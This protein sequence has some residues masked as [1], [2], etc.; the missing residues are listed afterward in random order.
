MKIGAWN[1]RTLMDSGTRPERITAIVGHELARYSIAIAA[2]SET[3]RA[4]TGNLKEV[5]AGYTFYWSGKPEL[6]PRESGVGF[7]IRND[8]ASN[9]TSLPKGL[10]DRL[11]TLRLPLSGN[12]HLTLIS[13]YA[14]T[15]MY[16]DEV[17]EQ[18]YKSLHDAIRTVPAKDKLV[19]LGDFNA[20]VGRNHQAW[21]G[22]LGPHGYG[23]ENSNGLMLLSLCSEESLVITNSIFEH[24]EAHKVTWMHPRSKHWHTIDYIITRRRDISDILDTRALRGADCWTDHILLRCKARFSIHKPQQKK[25][26]C[27]KSK[28]DVSKLKNR[29]VQDEL[30]CQLSEKLANISLENTSCEQAWTSFRDVVF[31]TSEST[32]GFSKRK[33][34]DWFDQSDTEILEQIKQKRAAHAAWLCDKNSSAKYNQFKQ[35]RTQVQAKTRLLKDQWWAAKAVQI[36]GHADKNETKELFAGLKRVFGPSSSTTTPIR[37]QEGRLLT[38]KEDILKQ[39]RLHFSSLLNRTSNVTQDALNTIPQRPPILLLDVPPDEV[40]TTAAIKQLQIGKAAGPDGIPPE[41]FKAGGQRLIHHLTELFQLFWEKGELPQDFR[42]ANI[43]HLYKNKG[44]K[45]QCDNHRGI[46]LLSIAGKIFAR[47][48]LNRISKHLLD[49]VV[50]ESQCGFRKQRGTVDMI[51]AVRQLQ[52]KCIEQHKD[53]HLLFIDLTKAFDTVSRPGLW[54]ILQRLGCPPKFVQMIRAFHDGMFG[55][56]IENGEASDP[57][58]VSNGVKQGCVLAPTLF[59]LLFAQM[60]SAA[61]KESDAGISIHYRTDGSVFNLRRLQSHTKVKKAVVR[62]FLFADDCALACHSE[63]DLQSLADCFATASKAFGLTVSLRKT[64]VLRQLAPDTY[65]PPPNIIME[66]QS[67]KNVDSFR[68]LGSCINS[69]GNLDDEVTFRLSRAAQAFG[70]LQ[71]RVWKEKGIT[72]KT[73]I[74]VYRAV[75]LPSLLYGCETWT[76]Y[77]RHIRKMEQ[78]H[79]RCLRRILRV[80]WEDRIPNQ[81]I[82]RKAGIDGVEV[83]LRKAQLRWSGHVIRMDD[84]R[85]PKQLFFAELAHGKRHQG[86]QRKRY[87][88]CLKVTLKSCNI[89]ISNW[90]QLAQDRNAWRSATR[91]GTEL[92]EKTRLDNLDAKRQD[93]KSRASES[94][95]TIPCPECGRLCASE[96]GLRSHLR[97]HRH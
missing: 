65:R 29:H 58:P 84:W 9:L 23:N 96:F 69:C 67:L 17:K 57:F 48:L 80:S 38:D 19:I 41:V 21:P 25:P 2:L 32:L 91:K 63:E 71:N 8:I 12:T 85:L 46:S 83:L 49:D 35:L 77:R 11:M 52:E 34:Q 28:L 39:W 24:C 72:T 26:S 75:V 92:F 53:L 54:A 33:H 1:V 79:L 42:D 37:N 6:E 94:V 89:P 51:F 61:L 68:Y 13:V 55:R 88:D 70:R 81:E 27:I 95:P 73:K 43:I 86:G 45:A 64:E 18:F 62:D 10:S 44:D 82:L 76:C 31:S 36:Q 78:F 59:S 87:K 22:V 97:R 47:I 3:R 66:G 20:R 40:E 16:P 74:A 93:R 14:P 7:A 15:M 90:Q 60:L 4:D 56:V 50:S 30:S 5:G